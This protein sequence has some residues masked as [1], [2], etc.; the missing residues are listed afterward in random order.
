M[1]RIIEVW[2]PVIG[3]EGFYDVSNLGNVRSVDRFIYQINR[4]GGLTKRLL[5]GRIIKQATINGGY[6]VVGLSKNGETKQKFVHILAAKAFIPN[7]NNYPIINHKDENPSNNN[8]DNLEWCTVQYNTTY[9]TGIERMVEKT[10]KKVYQYTLEGEL[11]NIY[12][13]TQ[14]CARNGYHQGNIS[15]CCNGKRPTHKG[16]RWSYEPL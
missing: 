5:K 14:E 15:M 12:S 16:Y 13:S 1:R 3:Y 11:V 6:K 10:S 9:G 8:L 4:W 2:R 7:P